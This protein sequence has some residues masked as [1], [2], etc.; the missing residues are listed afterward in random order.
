MPFTERDLCMD[1]FLTYTVFVLT[2]VVFLGFF[3]EKVTKFTYEISL[4]LF[5]I[6]FGALMLIMRL[7]F[8]EDT[9]VVQILDNLDLT[10][11]ETF[12]MEGVLCFMLFAGSCHMRLISQ[13][14]YRRRR[15]EDFSM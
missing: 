8:G 1:N 7:N 13:V 3:N 11:L 4:M 5:S 10:N 12:L 6:I 2:F 14:L 15:T 9:T